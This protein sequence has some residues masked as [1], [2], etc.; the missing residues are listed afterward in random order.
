[1]KLRLVPSLTALI[2]S[3]VLSGSA[4]GQSENRSFDARA[5]FKPSAKVSQSIRDCSN[6][7]CIVTV[8]QRAR[9]TAQAIAFTR[10]LNGGGFMTSFREMGRVDLAE[11]AFSAPTMY[12]DAGTLLINGDP[13]VINVDESKYY[14]KLDLRKDPLYA[15]L[16]KASPDIYA[17]SGVGFKTLQK[18]QN[19]GQRFVFISQLKSCHGCEPVGYADVAFD[20]DNRG[21]FL[22]TKLVQLRRLVQRTKR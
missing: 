6:V 15:S 4:I 18:L 7:S 14:D 21:N 17:W 3:F 1:M 19:G 5:I 12:N 8:M 2:V 9:A 13:V 16:A 11:Y 20:F 22:G 10:A